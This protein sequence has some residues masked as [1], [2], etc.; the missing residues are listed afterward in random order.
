MSQCQPMDREARVT[1]HPQRYSRGINWRCSVAMDVKQRKVARA[2][3]FHGTIVGSAPH[4]QSRELSG[5][6]AFAENAVGV[7]HHAIERETAFGETAKRCM[8]VAHEH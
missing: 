5:E 1:E 8:K 7:F 6:S 2:D 3:K 4:D